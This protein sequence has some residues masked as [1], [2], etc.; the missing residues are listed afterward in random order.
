LISKV[1]LTT[2][3][4]LLK[5]LARRDKCVS[6]EELE[7]IATLDQIL[8]DY[9]EVPNTLVSKADVLCFKT[10]VPI[11]LRALEY[12]VDPYVVAETLDWRDFEELVLHYLS[13]ADYE[14]I[15]SLKTF[16]KRYEIDVVAVNHTTGVG[17]VIDCKHWSPGYSKKSKLEY[18]AS[19]HRVK[20]EYIARECWSL[21]NKYKTL[22]KARHFTP[23]IVTLTE[24]L[25]EPRKG[26]FV[27]PISAFRDFVI[28]V[29]YYI[30]LLS[31]E[32]PLI[33]NPC[34]TP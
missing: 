14:V 32:V 15:H 31:K 18:V 33:P 7:K 13:L 21:R 20:T 2:Y 1:G 19:N 28:N 3:T 27:V 4:L 29:Q 34:Y 10:L 5:E 17:L 22:K 12:G 30:D 9:V 24:V 8:K 6:R 11:A 16:G 26:C 25:K 23:V